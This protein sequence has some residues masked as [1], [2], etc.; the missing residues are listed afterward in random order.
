[1]LG[2]WAGAPWRCLNARRRRA[3]NNGSRAGSFVCAAGPIE[4]GR[5]PSGRARIVWAHCTPGPLRRHRCWHG[6]KLGA[7]HTGTC[8]SQVLVGQIR[9]RKIPASSVSV[10]LGFRGFHRWHPQFS[11]PVSLVFEIFYFILL[12]S[13]NFGLVRSTQQNIRSCDFS[14]SFV[15]ATCILS[16]RYP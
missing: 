16:F 7:E 8:Q 2:A 3:R 10:I 13:R 14:Q 6:R 1:M 4:A 5:V 15:F 11:L 9:E 12:F